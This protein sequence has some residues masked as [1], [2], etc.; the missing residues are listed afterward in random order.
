MSGWGKGVTIEKNILFLFF[1]FWAIWSIISTFF[2]WKIGDSLTPFLME[3]SIT[4]FLKPSH[5][6]LSITIKNSLMQLLSTAISISLPFDIKYF[7]LGNK[8]L[9]QGRLPL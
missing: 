9:F 5:R 3:F 7:I 2:L 8:K 1:T 6:Q 4:F